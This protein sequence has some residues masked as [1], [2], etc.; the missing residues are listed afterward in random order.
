MI[1]LGKNKMLQYVYPIIY[2]IRFFYGEMLESLIL[3][4]FKIKILNA[5]NHFEQACIRQGIV[6]EKISEAKYGLSALIDELVLYS[7]WHGRIAWMSCPLQLQY[8]GEC[9]AG[10][11]FFQRL[12][13]IRQNVTENVELLEI[14]YVC[15]QFGFKGKYRHQQSDQLLN[16]KIDLIGQ[17]EIVYGSKNKTLSFDAIPSGLIKKVSREIPFWVIA[18]IGISCIF[19]L[20]TIYSFA[21][22]HQLDTCIANIAAQK[23]VLLSVAKNLGKV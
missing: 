14:Y 11:G 16:L 22:E 1:N 19:V 5:F 2:W 6:L 3:D 10:E 4:E 12:A 21:I 8:F 17:L 15:L 9:L 13:V 18:C 23:N 20:Y 7:T